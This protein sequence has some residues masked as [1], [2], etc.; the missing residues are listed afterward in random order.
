MLS[1]EIKANLNLKNKCYLFQINETSNLITEN[2]NET[3]TKSMNNFQTNA[4]Q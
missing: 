1:C 4:K 2:D 3:N